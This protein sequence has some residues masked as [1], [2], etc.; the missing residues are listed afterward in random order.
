MGAAP[1]GGVDIVVI[2][3]LVEVH[4]GV[5][6]SHADHGLQVPHC[7]GHAVA[8]GTLPSQLSIHL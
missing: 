3:V 8:D 6:L 5:C 7:D 1:D 4:G 2:D